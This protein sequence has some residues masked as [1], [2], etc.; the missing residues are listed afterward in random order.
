MIGTLITLLSGRLVVS[1]QVNHVG[2][3]GTGVESGRFIHPLAVLALDVCEEIPGC[4]AQIVK[5]ECL[6]TLIV[7]I[8]DFLLEGINLVLN[9]L[10][11]REVG[12]NAILTQIDGQVLH[13][14]LLGLVVDY[15]QGLHYLKCHHEEDQATRDFSPIAI[16]CVD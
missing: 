3:E 14:P 6:K 7:V 12:A 4:L 9:L 5:G 2:N 13:L 1:V 16:I 8:D 11:L 15:Q 10:H